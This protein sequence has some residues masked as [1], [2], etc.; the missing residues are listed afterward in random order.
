MRGRPLS[1]GPGTVARVPTQR[2]FSGRAWPWQWSAGACGSMLGWDVAVERAA[3]SDRDGGMD[4][5]REENGAPHRQ[6]SPAQPSPPQPSSAQSSPGTQDSEHDSAP[7]PRNT[8]NTRPA[9]RPPCAHPPKF[10]ATTPLE[11][12]G[13]PREYVALS[14]ATRHWLAAARRRR[15]G[16]VKRIVPEPRDWKTLRLDVGHP[17]GSTETVCSWINQPRRS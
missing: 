12:P 1:G 10:Q 13:P 7:A 4:G 5:W 11:E 14:S 17:V 2:V 15:P 8:R 9:H 16:L 3:K 6:P